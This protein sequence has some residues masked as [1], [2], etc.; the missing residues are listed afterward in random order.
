M[1]SDGRLSFFSVIFGN[2]EKC[3]LCRG[4]WEQEMVLASSE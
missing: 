3:F 1:G 2:V 4:V